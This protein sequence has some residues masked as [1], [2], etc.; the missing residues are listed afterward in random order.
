MDG[1]YSYRNDAWYSILTPDDRDIALDEAWGALIDEEYVSVG[2]AY[3]E[4]LA[5]TKQHQ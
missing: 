4:A 2:Q 5:V 1:V 3:F